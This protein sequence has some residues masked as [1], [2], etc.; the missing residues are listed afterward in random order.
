MEA[1]A[2]ARFTLGKQS[3]LAPECDGSEALFTAEAAQIP[4]GISSGIRLMFLANEGD[5]DGIREALESG[6]NV[7]FKDIDGRTALHVAA[8]QGYT[9]VVELLIRKG[10]DV[11]TQD[12]WGSTVLRCVDFTTFSFFIVFQKNGSFGRKFF[13]SFFYFYFYL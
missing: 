5:L 13:L 12:R 1:N 11:D 10:A 7:D 8:C 9:D 2:A 3:S 4:E 6:A